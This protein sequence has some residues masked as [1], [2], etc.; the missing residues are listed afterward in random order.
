M[1]GCCDRKIVKFSAIGIDD[2]RVPN[3]ADIRAPAS[4]AE[5]DRR[6][7]SMLPEQAAPRI[8][9]L[10]RGIAATCCGL[11]AV[12]VPSDGRRRVSRAGRLDDGR[13]QIHQLERLL[14]HRAGWQ[15]GRRPVQDQRGR[16]PA[17]MHPALVEPERRV[18]QIGPGPAVAGIGVVRPR[19][20]IRRVADPHR[21]PR[22]CRCAGRMSVP[23]ARMSRCSNSGRSS[24]EAPLSERKM[25][26]R[27][28]Q[29]AGSPAAPRD[30]ADAAVHAIDHARHR[31]ACGEAARLGR[32]RLGPR[33]AASDRG[34]SGWCP[35]GSTPSAT[36][37]AHALDPQPVPARI[38]HAVILRYVR[39]A[40]AAASAAR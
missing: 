16:D 3:R 34:R 39:S 2:R 37:R 40:R 28:R 10:R 32:S 4:T 33:P 31:P 23:I 35:A 12:P 5:P 22:V 6:I 38:E 19:D 11:P 17:L 25:Q 30:P 14:H 18:G 21:L 9:R 27:V 15:P 1:S 13:H 29:L 8:E 36:S 20:D 26:Q 7:A 24:G